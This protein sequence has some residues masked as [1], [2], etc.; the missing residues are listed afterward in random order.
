MSE[1]SAWSPEGVL[2]EDE[3]AKCPPALRGT[4]RT[5]LDELNA[6]EAPPLRLRY[7][8]VA[9]EAFMDA[10][11]ALETACHREA[12]H[13]RPAAINMIRAITTSVVVSKGDGRIPV[14]WN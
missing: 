14:S 6:M 4:L 10:V 8:P 1:R 12:A 11:Q 7:H 5:T 13:G 2:A 3:A 9:M